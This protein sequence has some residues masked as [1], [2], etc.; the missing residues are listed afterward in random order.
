MTD[1]RPRKGRPIHA[2]RAALLGLALVLASAVT[3]AAE[4]VALVIGE[5]NYQTLPVLKTP[6]LNASLMDDA[7]QSLHFKVTTLVDA[8][9]A[10]LSAALDQFA[11]QAATADTV[12]VYFSGSAFQYKGVNHLVPVDATLANPA[13]ID[14]ETLRLDAV[15]A[16]LTNAKR[17]LLVFI[18]SGPGNPLPAALQGDSGPGL[19]Q[20]AL[21]GSDPMMVA[22]SAEPGHAPM[23]ETGAFSTFTL[24]LQTYLPSAG[25][26]L[27]D[28]MRWVQR[29]LEAATGKAQSPWVYSTLDAAYSLSQTDQYVNAPPEPLPPAV[30]PESAV[31]PEAPARTAE[32]DPPKRMALRPILLPRGYDSAPRSGESAAPN[33]AL[34]P[35]VRQIAPGQHLAPLPPAADGLQ[36]AALP[37][38]TTL[39]PATPDLTALPGTEVLPDG[40]RVPMLD[41]AE[42]PKAIQ[43]ELARVG[44]YNGGIDGDFGAGSRSA[45]ADYFKAKN[46]PADQTD[47]TMPVYIQLL[48]ETDIVCKAA[49]P[50]PKPVAT[51]P[52]PQ[53]NTP[54][55]PQVNVAPAKP[56]PPVAAVP[57]NNGGKIKKLILIPNF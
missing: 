45:L 26:P 53:V 21:S 8:N 56:T 24:E 3:A 36:L 42:L 46:L 5:A 6:G 20:P 37:P 28:V 7:L 49:P 51:P 34:L 22:L 35:T 10:D 9:K 1:R 4:R 18:D 31:A 52:K 43:K 12:L 50:P 54:P 14:T 41:A 25:K 55:K 16:R 2:F 27:A 23:P 19:A 39:K 17:P 30:T 38:T 48:G 32:A 40:T 47:P 57:D 29:D 13:A 33:I 15:I 11:A 44:C